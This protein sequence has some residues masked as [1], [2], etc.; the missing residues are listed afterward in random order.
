MVEALDWLKR[1]KGNLVYG[2]IITNDDLLTFGE[3]LF[4]EDPCFELQQCVEKSIKAILI[5]HNIKFPKSH[6]IAELF[7]LL[8]SN[9]LIVPDNIRKAAELTQYAVKQGI[10]MSIGEFQKKNIVMQ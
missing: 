8:E 2:K 6:V 4:L 9:S 1:A 7:Y 10:L 5:F 3:D